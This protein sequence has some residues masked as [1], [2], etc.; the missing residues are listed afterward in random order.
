MDTGTLRLVKNSNVSIYLDYESPSYS[1]GLPALHRPPP[2]RLH[3]PFP[4]AP[5]HYSYSASEVPAL[6][7]L[8][9]FFTLAILF[10][11]FFFILIFF[12]GR[13]KL[14]S[15]WWTRT[16]ALGTGTLA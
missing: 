10:Y 16:F 9:F 13:S 1:G 5:I 14:A 4:T 11:F 15:S 12:F 3:T 7:H 8:Q 2:P 6:S